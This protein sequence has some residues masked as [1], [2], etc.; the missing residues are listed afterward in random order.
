MWIEDGRIAKV[1]VALLPAKA[2]PKTA[3]K[4]TDAAVLKELE[5]RKAIVND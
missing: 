3:D 2:A 5:F 4:V 1:T